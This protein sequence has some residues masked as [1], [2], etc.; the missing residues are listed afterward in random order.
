MAIDKF[1]RHK[2]IHKKISTIQQLDVDKECMFKPYHHF[3]MYVRKW[4]I[5]KT[6][7]H[8]DSIRILRGGK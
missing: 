2:T 5:R 7:N 4:E 6:E 8:L 1:M 3:K